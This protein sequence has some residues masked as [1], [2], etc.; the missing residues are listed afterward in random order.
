MSRELHLDLLESSHLLGDV[1]RRNALL[2]ANALA[3]ISGRSVK[4]LY[5]IMDSFP[6][7]SR[8]FEKITDGLYSDY[9][10]T[11]EKIRGALQLAHEVAGNKVVV[12]YEGLHNT[13]QHHIRDQLVD[14]FKG[15]AKLY[16]VPSYLAREDPTLP[17]YSPDDL[18][19]LM[20]QPDERIPMTVDSTLKLSIE[21]ELRNGNLVLC[22]SAGGG[23]SLDEWL[24][25]EFTTK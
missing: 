24:R 25:R 4:N 19:K 15:V 11:P 1:N 16:I 14:L 2:V 5:S 20:E 9:A 10:H 21:K 18:A 13:R 6:G 3:P 22:F 17:N 12:V 8:R 23:A 7:V